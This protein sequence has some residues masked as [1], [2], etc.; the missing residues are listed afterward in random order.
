[1]AYGT[2]RAIQQEQKLYCVRCTRGLVEKGVIVP[3][4]S[5][6]SIRDLAYSFSTYVL[7]DDES[8]GDGD[9]TGFEITDPFIE[10]LLSKGLLEVDK[11][12][13]EGQFPDQRV[14]EE[15]ACAQ[16]GK[17]LREF[18]TDY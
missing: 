17:L 13:V 5:R 8:A 4:D 3:K 10:K 7:W 1:M 16:C 12:L 14:L 11:V 15:H 18:C 2:P 9:G 6:Y